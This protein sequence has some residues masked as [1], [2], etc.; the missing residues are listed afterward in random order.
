[1]LPV[2][3]VFTKLIG[4]CRLAELLNVEEEN[5][6]GVFDLRLKMR[7]EA[8][9]IR[10]IRIIERGLNKSFQ[11]DHL[12]CCASNDFA[13]R[14]KSQSK[15]IIEIVP[16]ASPINSGAQVAHVANRLYLVE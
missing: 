1:M 15:P 2:G 3:M 5:F 13:A 9:R 14:P 6:G 8:M 11:F 10:E 12:I 4:K 16:F 7:E